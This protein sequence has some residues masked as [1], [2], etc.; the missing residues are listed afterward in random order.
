MEPRPIRRAWVSTDGSTGARNYDEFAQGHEAEAAIRERPDSMLS[1][2]LPEHE[3]AFADAG[4]DQDALLA[5]A[6]DRLQSMKD[7]GL[8]RRWDDA[9]VV[10]EIEGA[11]GHQLGVALMLPTGA[12]WD[13]EHNP[14]GWI[15]R[16]ERVFPDKL[17][18]RLA[19]L[20]AL[21]HYVS[22]V[23]LL[24]DD[25]DRSFA[26][27][28]QEAAGALP[29]HAEDVD[30]RGNR[31][32]IR[33]V[34][35]GDLQ[36]RLLA[37]L[38]GRELVVADGNHR[39]LA[40][41]ES[42]NERFLGVVMAA[43]TMRILPYNRLVVSLGMD[44][45]AFVGQL[46]AAGRAGVGVEGDLAVPAEPGHF[47]VR[48]PGRTL[49]LTPPPGG[50]DPV[51]RLDHRLVESLVFEGV[52]GMEATD[53]RIRYVGGDYGADYLQARVDGGECECAIALAAVRV[54]DFME[55]NRHRLRMPP[56]STWFR[57]KTR[58]GL[59]VAEV[60]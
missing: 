4:G 51:S 36:R 50:P 1:V 2:D 3:P 48:L 53:S 35:P 10:Y 25:P 9:V 43:E 34:P 45:A 5:H 13:A 44:E 28:V 19:H 41:Q 49:R 8:L 33:P 15:I 21:R 24:A 52:L 18:S 56:K 47:A 16:N 17:G 58:A 32:R 30:Q 60:E 12:V 6:A 7:R 11:E 22:S 29:L 42:G 38:T 46:R 23:L 54:E 59:V 37:R 40:A 27:L 20:R 26:G 31:H 14:E 39:S 57:P 55:V